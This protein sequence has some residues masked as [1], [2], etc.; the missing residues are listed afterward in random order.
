MAEFGERYLFP[1][2][3]EEVSVVQTALGIAQS[4][5]G[6]TVDE[7]LERLWRIDWAY[8]ALLVYRAGDEDRWSFVTVGLN[9]P[10]LGED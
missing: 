2:R 6:L 7:V 1:D 9:K 10:E 5:I 3:R 4:A 8:P